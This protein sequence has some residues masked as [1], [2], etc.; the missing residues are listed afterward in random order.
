M[1]NGKVTKKEKLKVVRKKWEGGGGDKER[2]GDI[3]II[4]DISDR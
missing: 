1:R 3:K 2:G 4:F